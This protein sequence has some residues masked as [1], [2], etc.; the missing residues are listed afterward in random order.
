VRSH[1]AV[2]F[3]CCCEVPPSL[4]HCARGSWTLVGL[5]GVDNVLQS[6]LQALVDFHGQVYSYEFSGLQRCSPPRVGMGDTR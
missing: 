1:F 4:C 5:L 6:M 2:L 3:Q